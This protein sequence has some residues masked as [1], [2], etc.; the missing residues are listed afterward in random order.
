MRVHKGD[1]LV[2]DLGQGEGSEQRG[3]RPVLV[4]QND[5]GNAFSPTTL[6]AA[7]TSSN[8]KVY[9]EGNLPTHVECDIIGKDGGVNKSVVLLEQIRTV[10]KCRI[11]RVVGRLDLDTMDKVNKAIKVSFGIS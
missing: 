11:K 6:V 10:D 9:R 5:V 1:I 2:C 3:I 4:L 8:G 7:I